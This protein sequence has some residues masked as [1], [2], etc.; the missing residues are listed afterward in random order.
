VWLVDMAAVLD[1]TDSTT[2]V[3]PTLRLREQPGQTMME[4]LIA[5]LRGKRLL[6]IFDNCEQIVSACA[7]LAEKLLKACPELHILA[8]SREALAVAGETTWRLPSLPVPPAQPLDSFEKLAENPSVRLFVDRSTSVV[9][10]FQL[11]AGNAP[12]VA[13]ICR[14]LDGIPLAIELAA[15]RVKMI[16]PEE[17][18]LR[19]N[20]RFRLLTGGSRTALPRHQTL[21]A[22]IDWSYH[23]LGGA[24]GVL[25]RRLSLFPGSFSLEV[26]ESICQGPDLDSMDIMDS[27][28]RLVDKSLLILE[29]S[30]GSARYRMLETIREYAFDRLR[31]SGETAQ[32]QSQFLEF[33][34]DFGQ[35]GPQEL[36]GPALG[37]WVE[38]LES[39]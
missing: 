31:E 22:A 6:L 38:G 13:K 7:V 28:S 15:A 27:V 23:L 24:E 10:D 2:T 20:D 8:T 18:A 32:L 21:R 16:S 34:V 35:R 17:I 26:A 37:G 14:R 36:S 1:S 9:P 3:P 5:F 19:L 33:F 25:F 29:P 39:V 30:E 12:A 11:T 4:A